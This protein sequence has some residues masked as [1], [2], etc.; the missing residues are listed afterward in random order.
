M[1]IKISRELVWTLKT[2]QGKINIEHFTDSHEI[3]FHGVKQYVS[4][5]QHISVSVDVSDYS[6]PL[7]DIIACEKWMN[8]VYKCFYSNVPYGIDIG[9]FKKLFPERIDFQANTIFF[10]C[11]YFNYKPTWKDW[12]IVE[13]D[14]NASELTIKLLPDIRN[15]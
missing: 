8:S 6:S 5:V 15:P 1:E 14:I 11:S 3:N 13:G 4:G 7:N 10:N 12:F 2:L 9:P